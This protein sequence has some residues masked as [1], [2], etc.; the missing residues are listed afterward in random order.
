MDK[1]LAEGIKMTVEEDL[2]EITKAKLDI[3]MLR[4][5]IEKDP[6]YIKNNKEIERLNN[7]IKNREMSSEDILKKYVSSELEID[8]DNPDIEA[9]ELKKLWCEGVA[10]LDLEERK[11]KTPAGSVIFKVMPDN[12]EYDIPKLINW[13]KDDD[14]RRMRY[15]KVIEEIRKDQLK[16]DFTL[17]LIGHDDICD[18]GVTITP[19]EPKFNYKLNGGL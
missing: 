7:V 5:D 4:R 9:E 8:F 3:L 16:K 11:I 17:G 13:A 1:Y 2:K 15:L 10:K 19:Q 18:E 12:W 6:L 14:D